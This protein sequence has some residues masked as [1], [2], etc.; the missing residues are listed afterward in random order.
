MEVFQQNPDLY[1]R[2]IITEEASRAV[3][4][5]CAGM[6]FTQDPSSWFRAR[7]TRFSP[8]AGWTWVEGAGC[9]MPSDR[10]D[11]ASSCPRP[12]DAVA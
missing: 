3:G 8:G 11:R 2:E 4:W 7:K 6:V 12:R 9:E 5:G 1:E 10:G